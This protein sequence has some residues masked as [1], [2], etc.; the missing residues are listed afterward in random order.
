M[1]P[2]PLRWPDAADAAIRGDLTVAAAYVTPA[3]GAVVTSVSPVGLGDR[4]AGTV[5]FTTSLGFPKKLERIM[6]D[7]HVA[8]A[9]HTREH[10]FAADNAYVLAQGRASVELSPSPQRLAELMRASEPFLGATKRGPVWD[11]LLREYHQERVFV[12]VALERVTVWADLAAREAHNVTGAAWPPMPDAQEPPRNGTGPRVDVAALARQ[13]DKLPHRLLAYRGKD[14]FPVIV[15]VH[16]TRHDATGL[17][18]DAPDG[19]LPPGGRRAGFLA[20]TFEPQCVG[21][22]MRTLT[23][24]LN[25]TDDGTAVYA[26]HTS[27]G[28]AAPPYRT[29]LT[30]SNGLLAKYGV[31]RAR[32]DGT[33]ERLQALADR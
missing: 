31:W 2:A 3:G 12:D 6:R 15:P 20:H 10:G 27:K 32:R 30:V 9:Y 16:I 8:L 29:L 14:A 21:L 19:L 33:A 11:W 23:G 4:E 5:G 1:T 28:L 7:P 22:G 24:W 26:P 18:L 13:I 17:H 25:V